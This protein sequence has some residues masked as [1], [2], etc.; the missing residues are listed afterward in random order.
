M[1][2]DKRGWVSISEWSGGWLRPLTSEDNNPTFPY[3]LLPCT[4]L[5]LPVSRGPAA[6]AGDMEGLV[7]GGREGVVAGLTLY[8]WAVVSPVC[9]SVSFSVPCG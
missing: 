3:I 1:G 4:P 8:L 2:V 6:W 9:A 7:F 5:P